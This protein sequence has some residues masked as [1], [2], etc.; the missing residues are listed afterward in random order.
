MKN[1]LKKF[2]RLSIVLSMLVAFSFNVLANEKI[3]P[4]NEESCPTLEFNLGRMSAEEESLFYKLVDEQVALEKENQKDNVNFNAEEFREQIIFLFKNEDINSVALGVRISN[5]TVGAA[6]N[7][8]LGLAVGGGVT[9]IQAYIR[10][11]GKQAASLLFT[12]TIRTRII[13][14]GAD[15]FA[16]AA[17]AA[18]QFVF[19]I[20]DPGTAIASYLD[21]IDCIPNN[22]YFDF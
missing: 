21:S 19:A 10:S 17:N 14:W 9:A 7:V 18:A 20:L 4:F 6:M 22:G 5:K 11:A 12:Q 16:W 3:L 2:V 1:F 8:A 13:A 15:G